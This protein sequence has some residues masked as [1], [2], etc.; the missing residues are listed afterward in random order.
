MFFSAII[1]SDKLNLIEPINNYLLGKC[2]FEDSRDKFVF[3]RSNSIFL[4]FLSSLDV[5][6]FSIFLI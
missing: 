6:G 4:K 2:I 5:S 3:K 1:F